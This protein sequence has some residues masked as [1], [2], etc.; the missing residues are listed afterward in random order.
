MADLEDAITELEAAT[1]ALVA[2]GMDDSERARAAV[3]RRESAIREVAALAGVVTLTEREQ[4]VRR[5]QAV[6]EGGAQALLKVAE[7][8][9]SATAEWRQWSR[10]YRGLGTSLGPGRTVDYRG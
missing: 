7:M 2:L 1:G 4:V 3:E 8:K 5:L 10:V 6:G 9:R